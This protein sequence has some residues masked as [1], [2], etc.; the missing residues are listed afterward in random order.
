VDN[1]NEIVIKVKPGSV[2][3]AVI[4]EI[5]G[6]FSIWHMNPGHPPRIE[7]GGELIFRIQAGNPET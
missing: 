1:Q 5:D 7:E 2:I 3:T 6:S 4:G